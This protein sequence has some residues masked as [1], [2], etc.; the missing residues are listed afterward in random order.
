MKKSFLQFAFLMLLSITLL[1]CSRNRPQPDEIGV[2]M[3]NYG[4]EGVKSFKTVTGSQGFFLYPSE[5]LYRIPAWLQTG[6]PERMTILTKNVGT[7]YIDP[8]FT[9]K[10]DRLKGDSLVYEYR[11]YAKDSQTF[12]SNIEK[13]ILNKK[14][15]DA[16]REEARNYTTDSLMTNMNTFER[17]VERRLNKEFSKMFFKLETITSGLTPDKSLTDEINRTNAS[18]QRK[19]TIANDIENAKELQRQANIEAETNRIKSSGLTPM[20]ISKEWVD[21]LKNT[22]NKVIVTQPGT[23]VMVNTK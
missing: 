2:L 10:A 15:T 7:F 23:S 18:L 8:A 1:S 16:Y 17:Q 9:Y 6:D 5:E 3:S 21:M 20:V 14:V 11:N 4:R 13:N 22:N 12:F 19:K